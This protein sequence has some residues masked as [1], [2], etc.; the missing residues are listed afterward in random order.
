MVKKFWEEDRGFFVIYII[1]V[2]FLIGF[3]LLA[4][5]WS[6]LTC[7]IAMDD[8]Y[9]YFSIARNLASGNG[10]TYTDEWTNGFQ[11]LWL[12]LI[13]PFFYIFHSALLPVKLSVF[14]SCI[15]F[16]LSGIWV[17]KSV[18]LLKQDYRLA[19]FSSFLWLSNP[20]VTILAIN[21][22][23]T[24]LYLFC[25]GMLF[26]FYFKLHKLNPEIKIKDWFI[27]GLLSGITFIA[28]VD[29]V[30]ILLVLWLDALVD[31]FKKSQARIKV[32]KDFFVAIIAF[33]AL[34]I[35]VV[36]YNLWVWRNPLPVSGLAINVD[37]CKSIKGDFRI[38]WTI[39]ALLQLPLFYPLSYITPFPFLAYEK[40]LGY[41]LFGLK[42]W[43]ALQICLLLLGISIWLT[44]L[45]SS[46]DLR[47]KVSEGAYNL[48]LCSGLMILLAYNILPSAPWFIARY[49]LPMDL[50]FVFYI[51][52]LWYEVLKKREYF[53]KIFCVIVLAF[54]ILITPKIIKRAESGYF[55]FRIPYVER[56][57]AEVPISEPIGS[58]Q[59]GVIHYYLTSLGYK[60]YN[61]DGKVSP[62]AYRALRSH[63]LD[64]FVKEK[65]IGYLFDWKRVLFCFIKEYGLRENIDY[66]LIEEYKNDWLIK[67]KFNGRDKKG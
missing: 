59:S 62:E 8:A 22:M 7:S 27:L 25:L 12:F 10:I 23:E 40:Q 15:F 52:T 49:L 42:G 18:I 38:I 14:F 29:A 66:E 48:L 31:G 65:K 1:L 46:K 36:I 19:W 64:E 3:S 6:K 13:T 54:F 51:S 53:F 44:A 67:L 37:I 60:V 61:L 9:Y 63:K 45:F 17:W 16:I 56:I 30:F 21:G 33:L 4:L 28:R 35:P 55:V 57:K 34:S 43:Y 58:F 32:V 20:Y 39:I 24:S 47:S 50:F 11:P 41:V 5:L 26:Y 2:I